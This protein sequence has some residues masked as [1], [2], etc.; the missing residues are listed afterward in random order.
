MNLLSQYIVSL[1][2]LYGVVPKDVIADIY[3]Q[4]NNEQVTSQDVEDCF[5]S[6]VQE[7]EKHFVYKEGNFFA[8]ETILVHDDIDETLEKQAG[9]PR[10]VPDKSELMNYMDEFYFY[11]SE[12]YNNLYDYVMKHLLDENEER[13]ESICEDV[14]GMIEVNANFSTVMSMFDQLGIEFNSKHQ[15]DQVKQLVRKL[16]D[17]VRLWTNKGHTNKE[18]KSFGFNNTRSATHE[19]PAK[20][21]KLGRNDPC[22]CGS[23]KKYKKCCLDKEIKSQ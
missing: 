8:H 12:A 23:G 7:I 16:Q 1:T 3:N 14:E 20:K 2:K 22:H 15:R 5:D 21:K 13:I 19:K 6:S 18:L 4:Q 11:K 10:Y 9:K 17:N